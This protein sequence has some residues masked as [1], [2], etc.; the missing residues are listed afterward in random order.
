MNTKT[1]K[2]TVSK[3]VT[4]APPARNPETTIP[5]GALQSLVGLSE[6]LKKMGPKGARRGPAAAPRII[7]TSSG[8]ELRFD[9]AEPAQETAHDAAGL[10]AV[11]KRVEQIEQ[12][13]EPL[14]KKT[15]RAQHGAGIA[16][17]RLAKIEAELKA[18]RQS[19]AA[20]HEAVTKDSSAIEKTLASHSAAIDSVRAALSQNEE[21]VEGIVETLQMLNGVSDDL[22]EEPLAAAS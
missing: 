9:G 8:M 7:L 11:L 22:M 16:P 17:E 2:K 3:A 1:K 5:L 20:L 13:L 18:L 4:K 21:L 12:T 6:T 10:S 14:L 15:A 19:T